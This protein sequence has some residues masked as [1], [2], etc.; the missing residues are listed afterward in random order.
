M[1]GLGETFGLVPVGHVGGDGEGAAAELAQ[2][3][4]AAAP[5]ASSLRPATTTS[6]R[7]AFRERKA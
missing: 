2:R 1:P 6:R 3:S 4:S 7:R 5:Q